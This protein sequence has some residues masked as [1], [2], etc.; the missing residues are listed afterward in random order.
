MKKE[1]HS[2][3]IF[4]LSFILDRWFSVAAEHFFRKLD[5]FF[6]ID[7]T[8]FPFLAQLRCPFFDHARRFALEF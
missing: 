8:F 3:R 1:G 7:G 6:Q 5:I 2:F 4:P